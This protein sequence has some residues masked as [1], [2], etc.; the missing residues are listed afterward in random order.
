MR[1]T[2]CGD[3]H[4]VSEAIGFC[5]RC[6]RTHF[7]KVWPHIKEVHKLSRRRFGLPEEPPRS[8]AG[9]PCNICVN[10][11]SIP[12]GERGY[13]GV[14]INRG[15]KLSGGTSR[16]GYLCWYYDPLPT[17]CVA[18]WVCPGGTGRGYPQY[19]HRK[20]PEHGYKNLAVFYRACSFNCLFCQNWHYREPAPWQD[21][22]SASKLADAVDEETACICYFG[23]DPTPQLP[24]AIATSHLALEK[25]RGSILRIC[26]ET[27][28]TMH[29]SYLE[30][31][32]RLSLKS[33]GCIK[34][35]LKAWSQE[36]HLAL[37]GITNKRTLENFQLAAQWIKERPEPPLLVASTLLVPGY[38][39]EQEVANIARFIASLNPG[40][41]Y[42]LLAFYP[43]FYMGDLPATSS[44]HA[45]GCK[46]AAEAQGLKE[47][48]LGNVH[49]LSS[50]Y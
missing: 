41:P 36:V 45:L 8:P 43:N 42:S 4:L 37:C 22:T 23:G 34:F 28:G 24:H 14:R 46:E 1:C 49:L 50:K 5:L 19:C 33:G 31:M 25:R 35:D 16:E 18:D 6:V 11:C 40:I 12:E 20:G 15:G 44:R 9:V 48:R 7:R 26:W 39:D 2:H 29:S 47:V 17:N 27:N 3:N 38:V 13:C 21:N 32:V 10:E 30:E